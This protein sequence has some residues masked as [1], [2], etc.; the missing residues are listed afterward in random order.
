MLMEQES[1][2]NQAEKRLQQLQLA[3]SRDAAQRQ[4]AVP[5]EEAHQ[6][7]EDRNIGE[8]DPSGRADAAPALWPHIKSDKS[9]YRQSDDECPANHL[10][11]AQP[12]RQTAAN[13]MRFNVAQSRSQR[14]FTVLEKAL[15]SSR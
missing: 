12:A 9:H 6:H 7:T 1:C 14:L 3:D 10:P 15:A 8:S 5:K 11:A 4:P 2:E 13:Y